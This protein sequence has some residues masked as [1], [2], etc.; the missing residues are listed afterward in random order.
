MKT[1]VEKKKDEAKHS[2]IV[3]QKGWEAGRQQLV[4]KER[5]LTHAKNDCPEV[6]R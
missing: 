5:E 3:S 4:V 1:P 6:I 2:R